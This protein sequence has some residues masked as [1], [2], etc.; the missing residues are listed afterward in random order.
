[1]NLDILYSAEAWI[2]PAI[3][4]VLILTSIETGF[5]L[6]RLQAARAGERVKAHILVVEGALVGVL[7]LLL[8]FTMSMAV[9]RFETRK[10]LVLEDANA[11]GTAY[12]RTKLLPVAEGTEIASLLR[13]YVDLRLQ[14]VA[15]GDTR[16]NVKAARKRIE[17][18]Q[19][20]FWMRAVEY[21]R[22]DSNPVTSGLLLQALNDVIDLDAARWMSFYNHVP[23]AVIYLN[24]IVALL[25]ATLVGYAYGI[26]DNRHVFSMCLLGLAIA[27]VLAVI[28]DLDRPQRG[29]IRVSQ[30]PMIDLRDQLHATQQARAQPT[31]RL[32]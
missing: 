16:E 20:A 17:T 1:V 19:D 6:G 18:L 11:I 8:A 30:Q 29:F 28:I 7:G 27:V 21:G 2:A 14:V 22:K 5:R 31:A 9:S 10:Q 12:L 24:A 32:P 26:D 15:A 25:T 3:F 4:V 23:S 13:D